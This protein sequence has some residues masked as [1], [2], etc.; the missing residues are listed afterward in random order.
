MRSPSALFVLA[1]LSSTPTSLLA[2]D[3]PVLVQQV[4]PDGVAGRTWAAGEPVSAGVPLAVEEAISDVR[5]LGMSGTSAAQ[6]RVLQRDP[7]TG[8]ITWVLATFAA[9]GGPYALR[10]G[11]G[12]FGGT[13]LATEASGRIVVSTGAAQFEIRKSGFNLL[14]RVLVSGSEI[15]GTHADGGV[16]LTVA[17]SRYESGRD[18]ASEVVIE[19]N[20]P[21]MAV[22]RARGTL[23]S[24]TGAAALEYTVRLHF[25]KNASFCRTFVTLR[26]ASLAS[27]SAKTFDAAWAEIPLRLAADRNVLFG[28]PG[29]GF[30]GQIGAGGTA[31]LFQADNMFERS[32]R[33]DYIMA[34]LTSAAGL[35]VAIG[36]QVH[37]VLGTTTDV[38]RGWMRVQD[39]NFGVLA[40]MRD[41]AAYFPSGFD[42]QGDR[43]AVELFSRYNP[44]TGLV[45][46]WGAHETREI[47]FEFGRAGLDTERFRHRVQY[48]LLGRCTFERY[49]DTGAHCGE[50]RLVSA[51]EESA[52]FAALG[53]SWQ[54]KRYAETDIRFERQYSFSTTG[55]GNQFDQDECHLLDF[56]R[57]GYAG[58][59][60]QGRIQ[61]LWKADQSVTHSDDFD[62][63][64]YRNGVNDIRVDQ[65]ASFHGKGAGNL[66]EDEHPHWVSMLL[67]YHLTGD[68]RVRESILDYG[69]WRQALA[70]NPTYG[71][72]WG[73]ALGHFRLWSR[74]FRDVALLYEMT[75]DQTYLDHVRRMADVLTTTYE[76]GTSKGRNLD[77]G[78]FYF[79]EETD[80]TRRIHVFFLI[81]MNAIGTQEAM[82]VLPDEDPLKEEL[83]DYLA[84][85]AWFT[86]QEVQVLPTA[87]GYPY[88]YFAAA[89]NE[90]GTRGDQTGILLTHGYEMTGNPEFV[91]R[92]RNLT[93]RVQEYQHWLRASELSTHL[94]IYR[95]LHRNE[96]DVDFI[97][98]TSP[99]VRNSNGSY[100]LRWTAVPG[101]SEY[102]VKGGP[103]EL[104]ENLGF[105]PVSRV[106]L[107]DPAQRMNFWAARNFAGEPTPGAAG[108]VETFTTPV[109][110]AGWHFAIK[111]LAKQSLFEPGNLP[112][113][114]VRLPTGSRGSQPSP[115]GKGSLQAPGSAGASAA[116]GRPQRLSVAPSPDRSAFIF[117]GVPAGATLH[118]YDVAGR[119]V[120]ELHAD[121]SGTI[122][123]GLDSNSG[124]RIASGVVLYRLDTEQVSRRG[125]LVVV[126]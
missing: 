112:L 61:A 71:A 98:P 11:T 21:V 102:I 99:P 17:G 118:L 18:T 120:R 88:G 95:W 32:P 78:Y 82:R 69:E 93:W 39:A 124:A 76:V 113:G 74:C 66:F 64:D 111:A 115:P 92:S 51:E 45:F 41:L 57:T 16:V 73:G 81:E 77:R 10:N 123:W 83:R 65:P 7:H 22:V 97:R 125:R 3:V 53:K 56:M 27:L 29:N 84:G 85:L 25:Y 55:G 23:R 86:L 91:N 94:R 89:P 5:S 114:E 90:V 19:D 12:N 54:V 72:L 52:F 59:F 35:E 63:S 33:T 103:E 13:N 106:F 47:L 62:Y 104:V 24:V 58:R 4:L 2:L 110:P 9:D 30:S 31:H 126:R 50:R 96:V 38:A 116:P 8:R 40:G 122:V 67:Y 79:G 49:R 119:L 36:G 6:F 75:G 108:T 101:A 28:F 14:D 43:L 34:N 1:L 121:D 70:G 87:I 117:A 80:V 48:P 37:N 42:L 60:Q 26:N 109:L 100:T 46:S 20:G 107:T 15:V 44:R 68:E 105:D